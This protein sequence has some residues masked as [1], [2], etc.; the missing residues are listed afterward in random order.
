MEMLEEAIAELRGEARA[1]EID[2]E[3]RL[4]VP[5]QLPEDYVPDVSQ[6]LVLYKRLVRR[7]DEAER[8]PHPRRAPRPLRPAARRG[9]RTCSR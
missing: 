2:P 1:T 3:I 8:R 6:R 7:R 9:R 4:P 5:A